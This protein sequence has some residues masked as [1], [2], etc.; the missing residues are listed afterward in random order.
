VTEGVDES[1]LRTSHR[2]DRDELWRVY[3]THSSILSGIYVYGGSVEKRRA[4]AFAAAAASAANLKR[5][6]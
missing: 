5:R 3:Q 6:S 4:M 1:G 2:P